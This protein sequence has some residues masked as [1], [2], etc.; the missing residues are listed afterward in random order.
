[1]R[2]A[3]SWFALAATT[4]LLTCC[5]VRA[6]E[7]EA[8][9]SLRSCALMLVD[10]SVYPQLKEPL[11][12]YI[13]HVRSSRGVLVKPVVKN[14]YEMKP[15]AIRALLKQQYKNSSIPVV[16]AIMVGPI[17]HALR[18]KK[19]GIAIPSSFYYEDF[20]AK[21]LDEDGDGMFEKM[22]T[23]P[24]TNPT[25]IWTAWWVPPANDQSMQVR[26]LKTYLRKLDKY[27]RGQLAGQ[28]SRIGIDNLAEEQFGAYADNLCSHACF[29][30]CSP[31]PARPLPSAGPGLQG[32]KHA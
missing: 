27:Y 7:T 3:V 9:Q 18:G 22:I 12:G 2:R 11:Q 5:N 15:S 21:W 13:E 26:M 31:G 14:F 23:N 20:D 6:I 29:S 10:S 25:E 8:P 17:P 1:M 30:P 28:E 19:G 16:G 4:V 24:P 32:E